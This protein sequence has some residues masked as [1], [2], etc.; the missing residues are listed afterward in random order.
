[1]RPSGTTVD[2]DRQLS[3][4]P[5][6]PST[7]LS[8]RY[9]SAQWIGKSVDMITFTGST[10]TCRQHHGE[11]HGHRVEGDPRGRRLHD[12]HGDLWP[13]LG[14]HKPPGAAHQ[15]D[16]ARPRLGYIAKGTKGGPAGARQR[17]TIPVRQGVLVQPTLFAEIDPKAS[18]A[19]QE[20][21]GPVLAVIPYEDD[22]GA[23]RIANDLEVRAM[24][25][26]AR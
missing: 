16:P 13:P 5:R 7:S 26:P 15:P 4:G 14:P 22:D 10:A 18:I 19:Q 3:E 6:S 17:D 11:G 24:A 25:L 2:R 12:G 21:F 20:I 8:E 23:V 1:M 9:Q